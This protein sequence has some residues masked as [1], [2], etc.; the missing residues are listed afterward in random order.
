MK[1]LASI[2]ALSGL[3]AFSGGMHAQVKKWTLAECIDYA[4]AHN[5]EVKKSNN[6]IRSLEVQR[7]TLKNSFLPDL[8]ASASQNLTFG[9]SLNQN[10]TYENSNIRHSYFSVSTE[11][12][13]FS[14]FKQT[15]SISQNKFDL[16]AAEANKELIENDLSLNVTS[17]YFQILLNKEIYRIALEQIDLTREQENCTEML[18]EN[19]KAAGSQLYD[20][21][22][23]LAD[24]AG[25][26][27]PAE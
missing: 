15:A 4:I 24:S 23:Q 17:I 27:Y 10:N 9:R 1:V 25:I 3:F 2:L 7:N 19:G 8:N 13:V 20:V 5:I 21:R 16:L 22:A 14:G 18:I 12:P 6:Q 11:L 26:L